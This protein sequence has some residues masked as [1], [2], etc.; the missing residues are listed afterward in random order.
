MGIKKFDQIMILRVT[1]IG[2]QLGFDQLKWTIKYGQ[3]YDQMSKAGL[4]RDDFKVYPKL[5]KCLRSH[6]KIE[7][8]FD[9]ICD[10][11]RMA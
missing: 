7:E 6:G 9:T 8:F 4:W 5:A 10:C 3:K 1:Q 2:P 11:N